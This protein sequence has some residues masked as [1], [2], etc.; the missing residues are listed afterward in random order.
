M[1]GVVEIIEAHDDD[2]QE[3]HNKLEKG[4]K[5]RVEIEQRVEDVK[6]KIDSRNSRNKDQG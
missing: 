4:R 5:K 1:E 6:E 2:I 3:I